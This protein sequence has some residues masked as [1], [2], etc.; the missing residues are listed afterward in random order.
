MIK[1][2]VDSDVIPASRPK[3]GRGRAYIPKR[4]QDFQRIVQAAARSA[5]KDREPLDGEICA[6]VKIYRKWKRTARQSG[7]LDNL[8]KGIWDS[9][10]GIIFR[11]DAQ[12]VRC[13]AE[14]FQD[15]EHPRAEI[16]IGILETNKS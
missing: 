4:N 10:T 14:K 11:D 1:I 12:I 2:L 5:M 7:D 6:V 3:F 15:K 13:V 16:E 9:M 8:L